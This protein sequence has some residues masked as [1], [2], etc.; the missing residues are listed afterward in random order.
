MTDH[1]ALE[2]IRAAGGSVRYGWSGWL[3][4]VRGLRHDQVRKLAA[5]GELEV[6]TEPVVRWTARSR[7][8]SSTVI[9]V[10]TYRLPVVAG[11]TSR[12]SSGASEVS[13]IEADVARIS[14]DRLTWFQIGDLPRD[15][16]EELF[17]LHATGVDPRSTQRGFDAKVVPVRVVDVSGIDVSGYPAH[18]VASYVPEDLPSI[19]VAGGKLIDGGHRVAAAQQRGSRFLRAID[20]TGIV[21]LAST[22]YVADLT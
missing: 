19:V 10:I 12:V 17:G 1:D 5:R 20:S 3:G 6:S 18:V 15:M 9:T 8:I 16:R 4:G 2:A 11:A 13:E 14:E 7:G 21:D 22:G